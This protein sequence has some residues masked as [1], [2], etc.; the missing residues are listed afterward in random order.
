MSA[1]GNLTGQVGLGGGGVWGVVVEGAHVAYFCL[2]VA[3]GP[4]LQGLSVGWVQF[5]ARESVLWQVIFQYS[6]Q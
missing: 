1:F 3:L 2:Q 4:G 5:Y 6:L